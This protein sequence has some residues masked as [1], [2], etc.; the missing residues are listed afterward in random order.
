MQRIDTE[1]LTRL[2]NW[3]NGGIAPP[4]KFDIFFTNKCNLKCRFCNFPNKKEY[5]KELTD[6]ELL[7]L[8]R[9]AGL[10][11]AKVFGVLGGE[12]FIRKCAIKAMR[13]AKEYGMAGSLVTNGTLLDE[14]KIREIIDMEWDL[15]RFSI[16]GSNA[17]VHD[18]LRG[19]KGSFKKTIRTINLFQKIK[20][21]NKCLYPTIEMNTVICKKNISDVP[22]IFKLASDLHLKHIYLLP[23]INFSSG[24]N[25]LQ[26]SPKDSKQLLNILTRTDLKGVS[27]NIAELKRDCLFMKS[28][29]TNKIILSEEKKAKNTYIP[30]FLPWYGMSVD[31]EGYVTPCGQVDLENKVNIR[32]KPVKEIWFGQHFSKLRLDMRNKIMPKGCHR[33]CM[34]LIDENELLRKEL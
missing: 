33:C 11:G 23:M 20:E 27:S 32:D 18:L 12:P 29:E 16:D 8:I 14:T 7:S 31:A 2:K 13:T 19:V 28:S 3:F 17:R 26:I 34:P 21:E 24:I 15:I 22:K 30:C 6:D 25:D 9:Q 5:S 10:L 1:I 4:Y